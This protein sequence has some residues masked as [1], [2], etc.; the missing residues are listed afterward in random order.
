[1]CTNSKK[2]RTRGRERE[3]MSDGV[4]NTEIKGKREEQR[5]KKRA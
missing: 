4:R 1:M 3:G 2:E 5:E